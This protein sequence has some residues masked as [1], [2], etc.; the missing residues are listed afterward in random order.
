MFKMNQTKRVM[1]M[2]LFTSSLFSAFAAPA[3]KAAEKEEPLIPT[4]LKDAGIF[5]VSHVGLGAAVH[6]GL[7]QF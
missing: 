4:Y 1:G 2:M 6:R 3:K 5:T 7:V